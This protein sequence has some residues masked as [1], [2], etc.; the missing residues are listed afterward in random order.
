VSDSADWK[1]FSLDIITWEFEEPSSI[2]IEVKISR[3]SKYCNDIFLIHFAEERRK[4]Y[5]D[6]M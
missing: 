5:A 1:I 3:P 6:F 2:G 4:A